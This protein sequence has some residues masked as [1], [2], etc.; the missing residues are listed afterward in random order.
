MVPF[1]ALLGNWSPWRT[2]QPE[3]GGGTVIVGNA[4]TYAIGKPGWHRDVWGAFRRAMALPDRYHP[5]MVFELAPKEPTPKALVWKSQEVEL[6]EMI[7][8]VPDLLVPAR[9]V[10]W[11]V[12]NDQIRVVPLDQV[13]IHEVPVGVLATRAA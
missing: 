12:R 13:E 3:A 11:I 4:A 7:P 2:R 1:K 5:P 10:I 6:I 9:A 8:A